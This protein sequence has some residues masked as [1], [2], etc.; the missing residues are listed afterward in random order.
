MELP[1]LLDHDLTRIVGTV[2]ILDGKAIVTFKDGLRFDYEEVGFL[3]WAGFRP[4]K[5]ESRDGE[6]YLLQ[7]EV[8]EFSVPESPK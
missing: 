6:L 5:Q 2:A 7:A 4:L 1:I 3:S 8:F